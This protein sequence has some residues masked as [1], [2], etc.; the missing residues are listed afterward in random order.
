VTESDKKSG[1]S[2]LSRNDAVTAKVH[3]LVTADQR[4]TMWEVEEEQRIY[5]VS[6]KGILMKDL[7]M[8]CVSAKITPWLLTAQ[9]KKHYLSVASDMLN[10]QK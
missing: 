6:C 8:R 7:G 5:F 9:Q 10:V 4:L 3:D 2:S 1:C